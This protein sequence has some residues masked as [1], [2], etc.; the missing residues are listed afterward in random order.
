M[1]VTLLYLNN[2][3]LS[4]KL[5]PA[6]RKISQYFKQQNNLLN[7]KI[8]ISNSGGQYVY[9]YACKDYSNLF[10]VGNKRYVVRSKRSHQDAAL[11]E[12]GH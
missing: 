3:D 4:F 2:E 6:S 9:L 11:S 10:N 1:G 12:Y 8:R 5:W 7:H